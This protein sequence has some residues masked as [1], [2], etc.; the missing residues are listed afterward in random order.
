MASSSLQPSLLMDSLD[1]ANR[2]VIPA[3]LRDKDSYFFP[4]DLESLNVVR[5]LWPQLCI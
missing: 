1:K 4:F 3:V 5:F 2:L